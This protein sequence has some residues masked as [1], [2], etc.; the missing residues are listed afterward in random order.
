MQP[1]RTGRVPPC[2]RTG[3]RRLRILAATSVIIALLLSGIL[4]SPAVAQT[5]DGQKKPSG[6]QPA[7]VTCNEAAPVF[8]LLCVAYRVISNNHVDRV[9]NADLARAAAQRVREEELEARTEGTPPA[10]APP[11]PE[12]EEVCLEIDAVEDTMTA[13]EMAIRGMIQTLDDNSYFL[14]AAQ[15]QRFRDSVENRGSSGLGVAFALVDED[16]DPCLEVST[17]C[18]PVVSEVYNGSPASEAGLMAGD[19]LVELGD[20]FPADLGCEA[21]ADLD[22]FPSGTSVAVTVRR[23]GETISKTVEAAR[24][25]IPTARGH[26]VDDELGLLRL[27]SFASSAEADT[28]EVLGWLTSFGISGLVFDLRGNR[29]G[30]V[31]SAVG[32]AG[33]FLPDLATIVQMVSREKVETVS[34]RGKELHPDPVLLPMVVVTDKR[35]ASASELVTGALQDNGRVTVVGERTYGKNTGQSSYRLQVN[36]RAVAF[37]HITTIRWL[38]PDSRSAKGGFEPDIT[39]ELPSCLAP[40]EVAKRAISAIRPRVAELAIT[41]TPQHEAG[42]VE[43]DTV[44][45]TVSFTSP[46]RVVLNGGRP[47]LRLRVGSSDRIAVYES[48][49]GTARLV[50]EY[51]VA[52]SESDEDGISIGADSIIPGRASIGLPAGLEAILTHE[53]VDPDLRQQ[54]ADSQQDTVLHAVPPFVDTD[55]SMHRTSI[56]LIAIAGITRGCGAPGDR[57]FCPDAPVT[58]AQMATLLTRTL[59]LPA[60]DRDYFTDDDA[61]THQD[62][63]NRLAAAGISQGCGRRDNDQ[64]CPSEPVSRAQMATFL[65]RVLERIAAVTVLS[66]ARPS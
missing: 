14:T 16:F 35:S 10:C 23:G 11:A 63:I 41:S 9:D 24:L 15:Y 44:A 1:Q 65:A 26:V 19:V 4:P 28:R 6:E 64:Y 32:V 62:N 57:E 18:R 30:Y 31:D 56:D 12:F 21:V 13:V 58:R 47:Q 53:A 50:F 33:L 2:D 55:D 54:V 49:S 8:Q 59:D 17:T 25:A 7:R 66:G 27:D 22:R 61:T 39:M 43:G 29:G 38:T 46:V 5:G 20:V 51:V 36:G 34:A 48:G 3:L 52:E 60:A 37:L 45:V 40:S 42:Y